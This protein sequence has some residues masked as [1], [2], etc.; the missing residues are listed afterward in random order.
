[1]FTATN[2]NVF[3][4]TA[5]LE[6]Q[7]AVQ[8]AEVTIR[9]RKSVATAKTADYEVVVSIRLWYLQEGESV[10]DYAIT[11]EIRLVSKYGEIFRNNGTP[12]LLRA[13][14]LDKIAAWEK[15]SPAVAYQIPARFINTT[16]FEFSCHSEDFEFVWFHK[17]VVVKMQ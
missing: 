3:S 10:D 5:K 15:Y 9:G 14:P 16:S 6:F 1:M 11:I 4:W 12:K 17:G 2:R 8:E 13:S 7:R